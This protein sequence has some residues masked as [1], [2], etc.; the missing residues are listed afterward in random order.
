MVLTRISL[1][2]N[3]QVPITIEDATVYEPIFEEF[4]K[5]GLKPSQPPTQTLG[6]AN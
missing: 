6:S 4:K 1:F 3:P 5:A 2:F